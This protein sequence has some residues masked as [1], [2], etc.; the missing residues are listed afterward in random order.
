[1]NFQQ[2]Y[3]LNIDHDLSLA[4]GNENYMSP[5][6]ARQMNEDLALLPFWYAMPGSSV[7][8]ASA[9]NLEFLDEM[10]EAFGL[11]ENPVTL[12]VPCELDDGLCRKI[13]PWGWNKALRKRLLNAGIME[14]DVPSLSVIDRLRSLSHRSQAVNILPHLRLNSSFCGDSRFLVTLEDCRDY[15]LRHDSCL[16]KAPLSGSGKGLYWCKGEFT[17]YVS[18]WCDRISMSQEGVIGE[19]IYNKVMDFALEFQ[20][21]GIGHVRFVGYSLFKTNKKGAYESNELLSDAEI[22]CR[23]SQY[24]F[25][26]DLKL[27]RHC[28]EKELSIIF[29]NDY[30]GYLGVDMMICS[31]EELPVYRIHPCVE[32]NLR[33][34]MGL[35]ARFLYDRFLIS[36][37][38]GKLRIDYFMSNQDL[39]RYH[40]IM[41]E[42]YPL[43]IKGGKVHSG[44]F[45]L[46]PV[47]KPD[48]LYLA[49]AVVL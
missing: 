7:L 46:T 10:Q 31:F 20:S 47:A 11:I 41:T 33:M 22:E 30:S 34:N 44:Y 27:L 39:V 19:P 28:L 49:S 35:L 26:D 5:D 36:G 40:Q 3:I 16:L 38:E 23:L 12:T 42:R 25:I 18:G 17:R 15:V 4:N 14:R 21:D 29:G 37:V 43:L 24:V 2:L 48:C 45:P 1:M 13:V 6:S 32:I 9:Y 8:C